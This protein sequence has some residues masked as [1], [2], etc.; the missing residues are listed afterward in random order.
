MK[1]FRQK[2]NVWLEQKKDET[3]NNEVIELLKEVQKHIKKQESEEVYMVNKAYED[4]YRDKELSRGFKSSYYNETYKTHDFLKR[5][6][7]Y[8]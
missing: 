8:I 7:K 3:S 6:T 4:G 1:T 5:L 2:L